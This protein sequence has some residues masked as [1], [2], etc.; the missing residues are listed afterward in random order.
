MF[1]YLHQA[2][3]LIPHYS[4]VNLTRGTRQRHSDLVTTFVTFVTFVTLVTFVSCEPAECCVPSQT[5]PKVSDPRSISTVAFA[6]VH[7]YSRLTTEV[8]AHEANVKKTMRVVA[9][10]AIAVV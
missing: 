2:A 3:R 9:V 10:Y 1:R 4:N 7:P 6:R 8:R 5:Q